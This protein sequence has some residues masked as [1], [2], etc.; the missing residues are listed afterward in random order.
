MDDAALAKA[1]RAT[2]VFARIR[3]QQ[4]LRLVEALKRNGEIVAMTGD[5]VNDAPAMKAAQIGIAMGGRG[6]DVAREAGALVLLND[7]FAAIVATIRL[8]RRI[9]DNLR[10]AIEYIV[11]VHIPIA[12]LAILPLLSGLPL[13]LMPTQIALLEMVI[14]PAC[15]VVFEAEAE[16]P[17]V[18][19]RPPRDPATPILGRG[20]A[21]WALVQGGTAFLI[22]AGSLFLGAALGMAENA[23]R[24]LVF[25]VLVLMNIG[26]ILVNRSF[27]SSLREALLRPNPTL[28]L[29]VTAVLA[30]LAVALYWGPA[31]RLFHFGPLQL[32]D[33]AAVAAAGLVFLALLEALKG[34]ARR[35]LKVQI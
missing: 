17:D 31:Q 2:S 12:G 20:A 33:A 8:G 25:T 22:A 35:H 18:M 11:A 28:W 9:Y 6:T 15:S 13:I 34:L 26:L 21:L 14:D 19:V 23:L 3:P 24:A 5:G 1:V 16:E 27:R 7:D 4:K 30:V 32:D 10:K 29:L